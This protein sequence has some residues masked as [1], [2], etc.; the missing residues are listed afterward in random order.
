MMM[1]ALSEPPVWGH[2]Y[3]I[4]HSV[5]VEPHNKS[6]RPVSTQVRKLRLAYTEL[7]LPH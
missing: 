1:L 6:V 2:S 7:K 4:S 5:S 3:G